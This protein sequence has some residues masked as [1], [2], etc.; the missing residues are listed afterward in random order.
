MSVGSD[1]HAYVLGVMARNIYHLSF[2]DLGIALPA[3]RGGNLMRS[4]NEA[5]E[6]GWRDAKEGKF[7]W[8][9]APHTEVAY[10]LLLKSKTMRELLDDTQEMIYQNRL[11][12]QDAVLNFKDIIRLK[13]RYF[14]ENRANPQGL[15]VW[16]PR[17][18]YWLKELHW[19]ELKD[20]ADMIDWQ[21]ILT[22]HCENMAAPYF[23]YNG[24]EL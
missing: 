22:W 20:H 17:T 2:T 10:A 19:L 6:R 11:S 23:E 8:N 21:Q 18:P 9:N 16:K 1:E 14:N 13:V 7:Q 5:M 3:Y 4:Y 24:V 12:I 15:V